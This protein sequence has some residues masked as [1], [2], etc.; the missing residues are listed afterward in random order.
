MDIKERWLINRLHKLIQLGRFH[1]TDILSL[2]ILLRRF[3]SHNNT[4]SIKQLADFVAHIN[5]DR[6]ILKQYLKQIRDYLYDTSGSRELLSLKPVY[7]NTIIGLALNNIFKC[8]GLDSI[9]A[10]RMNDVTIS[11]ISLL[12][13]VEITI[14]DGLVSKLGVYISSTN[15]LLAGDIVLPQGHTAS[16]WIVSAEN[17]HELQLKE[18]GVGPIEFTGLTEAF[19]LD[20]KFWLEQL[21]RKNLTGQCCLK[22]P[23]EKGG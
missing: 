4:S 16:F 12:Q 14:D 11:I 19:C 18:L 9:D 15:V 22:Q 17:N 10:Y 1:E 23:F 20:G 13:D 21:P 2:L 8:M 6:G 3:A 7:T 5:K